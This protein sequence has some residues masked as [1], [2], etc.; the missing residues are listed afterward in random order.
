M[1]NNLVECGRCKKVMINEEYDLHECMPD[2]KT[3]KT[4]KFTHHYI[5]KNE[6]GNLIIG[7]RGQDGTKYDFVEVPE[8]KPNTKIPY[9][10]T[11]LKQPYK[12][13]NNETEPF[14]T[15]RRDI[16]DARETLNEN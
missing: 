13:T 1:L 4:I 10:P 12:T 3:W 15:I 2:I 14:F 7:I 5:I 9:M 6:K 8:D 11:S 16:N